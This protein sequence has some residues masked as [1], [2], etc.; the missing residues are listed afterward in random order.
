MDLPVGAGDQP[1]RRSIPARRR[2]RAHP[3]RWQPMEQRGECSDVRRHPGHR[4]RAVAPEPGDARSRLRRGGFPA[5]TVSWSRSSTPGC[6]RGRGC[7]NVEPGGDY[8]ETTDGL[9]DCDGHGTLVAGLIAGQPG[10][11][12]LRRCRARGAAGVDP[13]DVGEVL[14]A[15]TPAVTRARRGRR[16][17]SRRWAGRSCTPPT[18]VPG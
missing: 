14:A 8:V 18:S 2:H 11:R 17:T 3:G 6:G 7:P 5:A 16:S 12:R 15:Q 9:T 1:A 10:R 13:G 4:S